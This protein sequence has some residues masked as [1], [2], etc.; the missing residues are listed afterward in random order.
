MPDFMNQLGQSSFFGFKK[1][2]LGFLWIM[3]I[4]LPVS[5]LI[6]LV[7]WT[8]WLSYLE[9]I[10]KPLMALINLPPEALL[11]SHHP[12]RF[13]H[14]GRL[15]CSRRFESSRCF[16]HAGHSKRSRCRPPLSVPTRRRH[17]R[18]ARI[19]NLAPLLR[20]GASIRGFTLRVS[21][22]RQRTRRTRDRV[23]SGARVSQAHGRRRFLPAQ[24]TREGRNDS[25]ARRRTDWPLRSHL[26]AHAVRDGA[27][28]RARSGG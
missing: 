12:E 18:S 24:Q 28:A 3:K 16:E 9:F 11:R 26:E 6:A 20:G 23:R 17:A 13:E 25:R 15:E 5:L 4:I 27:R 8:G 1:G 22:H 21:Q 7:Q 14:L 10:L 2:L 19:R